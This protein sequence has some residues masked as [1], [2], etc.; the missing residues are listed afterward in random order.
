MRKPWHD[1]FYDPWEEAFSRLYCTGDTLSFTMQV[2]CVFVFGKTGQADQLAGQHDHISSE[3]TAKISRSRS[4]H[5]QR[6]GTY[7][8]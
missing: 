7:V 3:S 2:A 8:A 6:S 5:A 1:S 4:C